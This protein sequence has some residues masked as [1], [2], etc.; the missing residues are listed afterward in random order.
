VDG[1]VWKW[2]GESKE[3][4]KFKLLINDQIWSQ[5]EDLVATPGQKVEISPAF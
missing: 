5:G 1:K 2:I 4:L 3:Q